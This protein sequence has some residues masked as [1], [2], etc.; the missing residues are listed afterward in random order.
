M[1][2]A[3]DYLWSF[4]QPVMGSIGAA[5]L[6]GNIRAESAFIPRNLQNSYEKKL[7]YNDDSYTNAVDSGTYSAYSFAH[8]SA[9]YGLVQW[10]HWSRKQNLYNFIKERNLSIGSIEG[11]AA[12][13]MTELKAYGLLTKLQNETDLRRATELILKQYEKPA[14]Q[15]DANVTRRTG[16][17]KEILD[18]YD[19]KP[20]PVPDK[21]NLRAQI[22]ALY[23]IQ[24]QIGQII[25]Q[26]KEV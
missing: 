16:Y 5:A 19:K 6:M 2:A 1:S 22:E 12:F 18:T 11:Q 8:D 20:D 14:D 7:G 21:V 23:L 15:S 9:G 13:C 24:D 26:L 25:D 17:A 10:T 3:T 4:F